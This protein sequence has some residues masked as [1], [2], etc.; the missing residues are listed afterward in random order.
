[1][2]HSYSRSISA[3]LVGLALASQACTVVTKHDNPDSGAD[4][5]DSSDDEATDETTED[6]TDETDDSSSD[7]TSDTDDTS[8]ADASTDDGSDDTTIEADASTGAGTDA[9]ADGGGSTDDGDGGSTDTPTDDDGGG[10]ALP[11]APSFACGNPDTADALVLDGPVDTDQTWSGVVVVEGNIQVA[12]VEITIEAGTQFVMG[13][14]SSIEFGWN[15][16]AATVFANGT[17]DAPITFCGE[18]AEPGFWGSI[19]FGQNV[20]SNTALHNVLIN[21][22]GGDGTA[23][24]LDADVVIDTVVVSDSADTGVVANDFGDESNALF[25]TGSGGSAVILRHSSAAT[26]FPTGSNLTG[27]TDDVAVLD[28]D[29]IGEDTVLR[30]LGVPYS[31]PGGIQ[32]TSVELSIGEGVEIVFGADAKLEVGWN[33]NDSTFTIAG[34]EANPVVFRGENDEP[35]FWNGLS[36]ESNV[37]TDSSIEHLVLRHAGGGELFALDVRAAIS[38]SHITLEDNELGAQILA[39]GLAEGSTDW[40][41]TGTES[42]PLT[43]RPNT[44]VALPEAATLTGNTRDE[45]VV[46][47]IDFTATGTV[48]NLGV[49]YAVRD[50]IRTVDGSSMTIAAGTKFVMG[51]D[52]LFEIGWNGGEVS[53]FAN[54]TEDEPITFVGADEEAGYWVGVV[55]N[56][57]VASDAVVHGVTISHAGQ[58][59]PGAALTLHQAVD[60]SGSS[61]IDSAGYGVLKNEDDATDYEA[62]NTFENVAEGNVGSL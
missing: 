49:P 18:D 60:V 45:I 53:F 48:P 54:G 35:G 29:S 1:M 44:W 46:E 24:G 58:G 5:D 3:S 31:Q 26:H 42:A 16:N 27:N 17:S 57:N 22:A 51:A 61:F 2:K 47:E 52:R 33:G 15:G 37:H 12:D 13:V 8:G 7:E 6:T 14:D 28:F 41:I 9:G 38:A 34:T 32:V 21:G 50:H 56:D 19:W 23:L 20:T 30:D 59:D 40:T 11:S 62:G 43:I 25:V 55:I 39:Q 36:I 4:V 10:P